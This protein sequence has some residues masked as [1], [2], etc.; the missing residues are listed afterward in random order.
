MAII[1]NYSVE[2]LKKIVSNCKTMPELLHTIG[3]ISDSTKTRDTVNS[4]LEKYQIS[5][6]HFIQRPIGIKRSEDNIFIE[7]STASQATVRRWYKAGNYTEYKCS[8]CGL[9][10]IWQGKELTL[11]L[12][13]INGINNDDR[14][15]NLHWVCPNCNQQLETT[16]YKKMRTP[17]KE[18]KYCI[19]CGVEI[20][21]KSTRCLSCAAKQQIVPLE[22]MPITREELKE[23]IRTTPFTTIGTMYGYSDNAIRQWCDKFNL[24]RTKN[25]I[26]SYS[27][28]EWELI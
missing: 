25:D 20:N 27:D 13:H 15:E 28:K 12:D 4:R 16:G 14:L 19:D 2:E 3:Y 26:K 21:S 17:I 24:P 7:N 11:I 23:L 9:E 5:T 8:I 1:D 22:K 10:P 18:K 6:E